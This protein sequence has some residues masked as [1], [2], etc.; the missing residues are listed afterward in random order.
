MLVAV[1]DAVRDKVV[2]FAEVIPALRERLGVIDVASLPSRFTARTGQAFVGL[3]QLT[4]PLAH[5]GVGMNFRQ[6]R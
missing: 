6:N 1:L 3:P 2:S 4:E 5:M